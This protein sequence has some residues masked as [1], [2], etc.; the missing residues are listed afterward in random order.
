MLARYCITCLGH[1][2]R[3]RQSVDCA[4][5]TVSAEVP[6]LERTSRI[7]SFRGLGGLQFL[8]SNPRVA[9]EYIYYHSYSN[10]MVVA[11]L[12]YSSACANYDKRLLG[13][14]RG[15]KMYTYCTLYTRV[16]WR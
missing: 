11:I 7:I 16:H 14:N 6:E 8:F 15:L 10:G 9:T 12:F 2:F 5:L 4:S 13:N 3:L 1:V